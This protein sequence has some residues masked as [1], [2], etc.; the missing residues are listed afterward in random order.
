M[1]QWLDHTDLNTYKPNELKNNDESTNFI[2]I[3]RLHSQSLP[4]QPCRTYMQRRAIKAF[5][6]R[7][8]RVKGVWSVASGAPSV[9]CIRLDAHSYMLAHDTCS[10]SVF[11][12]LQPVQHRRFSNVADTA[13]PL[14]RRAS[15]VKW[16]RGA[17]GYPRCRGRR[18]GD[19]CR[20]EGWASPAVG[21]LSGER[22]HE[23]GQ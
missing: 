2:L 4:P 3:A 22:E 23:D 10:L 1:V 12:A 9:S 5:D 21:W 17:K 15:S 6:S 14:E 8:T 16:Q 18:G 20:R 19:D 13:T 7:R 11:I